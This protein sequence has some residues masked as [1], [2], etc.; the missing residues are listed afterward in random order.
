MIQRGDFIRC[1]LAARPVLLLSYGMAQAQNDRYSCSGTQ[2]S[3]AMQCEQYLRIGVHA[4]HC[5]C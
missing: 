5:G 1:G 3:V 2:S 4:L